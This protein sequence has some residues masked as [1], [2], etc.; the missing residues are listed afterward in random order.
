MGNFTWWLT[1]V[2]ASDCVGNSHTGNS[3][4]R[5]AEQS[6]E[7]SGV[8][9]SPSQTLG[10]RL[11]YWLQK[12]LTSLASFTKVRF[13]RKRQNCYVLRTFPNS[14]IFKHLKVI[15]QNVNV[16]LHDELVTWAGIVAGQKSRCPE[17]YSNIYEILFKTETLPYCIKTKFLFVRCLNRQLLAQQLAAGTWT[18]RLRAT[19]E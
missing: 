8:T 9:S 1:C 17:Y 16:P 5:T 7:S 18:F 13:W 6:G 2:S 4:V 19:D 12:T 15:L 14:F 10:L 3:R 11:S